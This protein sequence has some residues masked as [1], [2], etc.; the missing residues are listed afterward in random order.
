MVTS[1]RR[2]CQSLFECAYSRGKRS[3]IELALTSARRELINLLL[4]IKW[5]WV[6]L[7]LQTA[8]NARNLVEANA[9][10]R[11]SIQYDALVRL[12][13]VSDQFPVICTPTHIAFAPGSGPVSSPERVQRGITCGLPLRSLATLPRVGHM[14]S[15][16]NWTNSMTLFGRW[17]KKIPKSSH[18]I[19]SSSY[20]V[21]NTWICSSFTS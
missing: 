10:S 12:A 16:D 6:P 11:P 15:I 9:Y 2:Y 5:S 13:V 7:A 18:S 1:K 17:S 8:V 14:A 3:R 19:L 4:F 20:Y 21:L